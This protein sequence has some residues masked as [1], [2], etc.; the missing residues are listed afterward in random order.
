MTETEAPDWESLRAR[1]VEEIGLHARAVAAASGRERLGPRVMEAMGRVPRHEFVPEKLQRYAYENMPLPIGFEKSIS[2]PF[3]VALMLDLLAP[4]PGE[5]VLEIGTGLGYQ[6]AV[7]A[8]LAGTVCTVEIVSELA[9]DARRRLDRLG[10]V[11]VETR[12]GDGSQG[13]AEAGPFD[14]IIL[15]AAPETIPPR[16]VEQMKPRGRMVLPL[17]PEGEQELCLVTKSATG[18]IATRPVLEVSFMALVRPH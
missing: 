5:K 2:Q 11:G 14:A 18:R 15:A 16:L 17:G 9:A 4:E 10:Y 1:M 7:L 12:I 8:E 3:I 13:W 6:A